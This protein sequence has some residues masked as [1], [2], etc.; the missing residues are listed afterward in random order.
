MSFLRSSCVRC[1]IRAREATRTVHCREA[2]QREASCAI[3]SFTRIRPA[4]IPMLQRYGHKTD[5][6]ELGIALSVLEEGSSR[7]P[8]SFECIALQYICPILLL[9]GDLCLPEPKHGRRQE[10][11]R[12]ELGGGGGGS[13]L[14]R[15]RTSVALSGRYVVCQSEGKGAP[16]K[17][18]VTRERRGQ[19]TSASEQVPSNFA[20][21]GSCGSFTSKCPY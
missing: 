1:P 20:G 9:Y 3:G 8:R 17:A 11:N 2:V 19:P 21:M 14:V 6:G 13:P 4:K 12:C 7:P 16:K 15:S 18:F 5:V 10:R